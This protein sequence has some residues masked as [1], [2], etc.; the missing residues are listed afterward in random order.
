MEQ[1]NVAENVEGTA[2]SS[3]SQAAT[4]GTDTS[5]QQTLE[6]Q[7]SALVAQVSQLLQ[8]QGRQSQTSLPQPNGTNITDTN[9]T[10]DNTHN[11][12]S[13]WDQQSQTWLRSQNWYD[14]W[15]SWQQD[16]WQQRAD[17]NDRPYISHVKIP[18][19]NGDVKDFLIYSWRVKNLK[20]QV[21]QKDYKI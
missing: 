5:T 10:T 7:V 17:W 6:A 20:S 1:Q 9:N 12:N 16:S 21:S 19:F 14:G 3:A 4:S 13:R 11:W 18:E 2:T 8:A 15:Q